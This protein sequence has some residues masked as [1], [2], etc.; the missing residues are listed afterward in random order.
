MKKLTLETRAKKA[1][2]GRRALLAT[3]AAVGFAAMTVW[4]PSA[5]ASCP[6]GAQGEYLCGVLG[7]L[8]KGK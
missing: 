1:A 8:G 5:W 3:A 2:G 6:P 7:H 4:T